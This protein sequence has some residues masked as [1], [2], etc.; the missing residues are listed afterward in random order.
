MCVRVCVFA[1]L[2][3][4]VLCARFV[5]A[6][7]CVWLPTHARDQRPRGQLP[8]DTP[9]IELAAPIDRAPGRAVQPSGHG[10]APRLS[11]YRRHLASHSIHVYLEAPGAPHE[12]N[13]IG[14]LVHGL[15]GVSAET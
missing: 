7:L 12:D 1:V 9:P 11:K 15:G 6:R 13:N 3:V 10:R 2:R 8:R 5:W 4:V 14:H